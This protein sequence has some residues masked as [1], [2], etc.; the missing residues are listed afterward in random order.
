MTASITVSQKSFRP[1]CFVIVFV[2]RNIFGA[3]I[4]S[5]VISK[6]QQETARSGNE[7]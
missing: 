3:L 1:V 2:R 5:G 4:P 6:A 7:N